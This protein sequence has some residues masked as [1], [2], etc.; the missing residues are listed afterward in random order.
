MG[1][2]ELISATADLNRF[3][4]ALLIGALLGANPSTVDR[5]CVASA[6]PGVDVWQANATGDPNLR[7]ASPDVTA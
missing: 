4:A 6:W 2:G 3:C 1:G 7:A 5:V